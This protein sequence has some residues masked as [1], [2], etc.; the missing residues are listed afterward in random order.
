MSL[1]RSVGYYFYGWMVRLKNQTLHVA[2]SAQIRPGT[3]LGKHIRIG[4]RSWVQGSVGSYSYIGEDCR[5]SA[6]IGKFCSI[7]PCVK[8]VPGHHPIHYLSTAPVFFSSQR[9]CGTSF[10][11]RTVWEEERYADPEKKVAA[12]IGNDVWIGENVLIRGG[13]RIGNGAVIA[14]GAVVIQDAEPYGIYAGV[15]ARLIK[16]RFPDE[17]IRAL[18]ASAWWEKDESWLKAHIKDFQ[19]EIATPSDIGFD[20]EDDPPCKS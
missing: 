15:P 14:M 2:G 11:E 13:V 16:K 4:R 3:S 7:S 19:H 5:L 17:V 10:T 8:T 20:P 18:E 12:V 6:H 9:P 1:F